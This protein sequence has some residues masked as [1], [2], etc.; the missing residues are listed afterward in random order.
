MFCSRSSNNKISKLHERA[1]RIVY[2]DYNSKFEELLTK[3]SSFTIH[4]KN[5][6]TLEK[7]MFKTHHGFSHISFLDLFH[8]Y[9]Y[10]FY[11]LRSQ[12]DFQIPRINTTL[13]RTESVRYFGPIIWN[14]IPIETRSIQNVDLFKTNRNHKLETDK[15]LM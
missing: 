3:E 6:Q 14:N 10:N 11:S 13:K 9:N 4:H 1:L 8:N 15:L 7:E 5:I 12:L 2:D